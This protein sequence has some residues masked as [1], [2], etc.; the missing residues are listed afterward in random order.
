MGK[1]RLTEQLPNTE[2]NARSKEA[3]RKFMAKRF[4]LKKFGRELC[5]EKV[6]HSWDKVG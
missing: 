2:D 1:I 4:P 6:V 3:V 5:R